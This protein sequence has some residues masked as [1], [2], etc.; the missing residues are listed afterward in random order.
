M[1]GNVKWNQ[2]VVTKLKGEMRRRL[3]ACADELIAHTKKLISIEGAGLASERVRRVRSKKTGKLVKSRK[4]IYGKYPS[5]PGEPPHRQTG[6]LNESITKAWAG[7]F[8]IKVGTP[9]PYGKYLEF[10]TKKMAARPWL[11]RSLREM[12][13]RINEILGKP[14]K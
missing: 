2:S 5:K 6:K 8:T 10:G 4:M 1:A 9:K 11:N 7:P 14:I 12:Q 3:A 13:K